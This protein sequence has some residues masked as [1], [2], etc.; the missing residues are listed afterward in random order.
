M[1]TNILV[2]HFRHV[3]AVVG[4]I[5]TLGLKLFPWKPPLVPCGGFSGR[6]P[7]K[8]KFRR[9]QTEPMPKPTSRSSVLQS[10]FGTW[11]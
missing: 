10:E 4:V 7:L 3:L 9:L 6:K 8:K 11:F 2:L 1:S 5:P